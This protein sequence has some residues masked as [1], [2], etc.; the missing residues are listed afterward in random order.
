M[1]EERPELAAIRKWNTYLE[2]MMMAQQE[3]KSFLEL[4]RNVRNFEN[5]PRGAGKFL[6]LATSRS[7][8]EVATERL[9]TYARK[10]EGGLQGMVV[11]LESQPKKEEVK[12]DRRL[13]RERKS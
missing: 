12:N 5:L 9:M 4:R 13:Q 2:C 10:Y 11:K 6:G 1:Q 7:T 8:F 3:W